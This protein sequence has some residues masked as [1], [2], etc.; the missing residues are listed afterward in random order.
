[1]YLRAAGMC[2]SQGINYLLYG[3]QVGRL[4]TCFQNPPHVGTVE[5][6]LVKQLFPQELNTG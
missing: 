5:S 2:Y 6:T 1:M 3:R 4:G